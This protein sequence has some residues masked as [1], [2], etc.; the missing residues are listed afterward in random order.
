MSIYQFN[1]Y[2][3]FFNDWVQKQPKSGHGEYRRLAISLGVST[4]LISQIFNGNKQVSLEI[5]SDIC[6][7]LHL[8]DDESEYFLLLVEHDKAGSYKLQNRIKKQVKDRQDKAKKL[9]NRLKKETV[10]DE[11]ARQTYYS[12]WIYPALRILVDLPSMSSIEQIATHLEI[13]KNQ[14]IKI[15]DFMMQNNLIIQQNGKFEMGSSSVYLPPSDPLASRNHQNWRNLGYQKMIF[16]NE[17]NFFYTGLYSLSEEVADHIRQ[18]LP[19]FIEDIL[20]RVKPSHSETTRC[21]NIDFFEF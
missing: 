21:L 3:D 20:K 18:K 17:S 15:L 8:N 10:L 2:K 6:D 13:P 16:S 5:A 7:Y 14:L 19:D 11:T 12:S 9:E 4:T 1:S